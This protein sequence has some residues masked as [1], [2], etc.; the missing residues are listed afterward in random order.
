MKRTRE[1]RRN[2]ELTPE[3]AIRARRVR[4]ADR[5]ALYAL[6]RKVAVL[7]AVVFVLFGVVF[8]LT[9]MKGGDMQPKFAAGDLLLYYRLQDSYV[10]NDVVVIERDGGQYVGRI[11]GMPGDTIE[12]TES[13]TVSIDGKEVVETEIYFETEA[14]QDA[15]RY[16]ITLG[17]GEYFLLGDHRETARDSR[18]FGPVRQDELRGKVISALRRTDI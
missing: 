18:Y 9:P 14:F 1:T 6:L 15:V 16:P 13:K 4:L 12:I 3:A 17:A 7:A 11:I 5:R 2:A 8:G 10:R